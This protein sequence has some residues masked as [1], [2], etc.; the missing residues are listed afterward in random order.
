M[1]SS[2]GGGGGGRG[3]HVRHGS[4]HLADK[5]IPPSAPVVS[6]WRTPWPLPEPLVFRWRR[7]VGR[8][9]GARMLNCT[10]CCGAS[11]NSGTSI[12]RSR[13]SDY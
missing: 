6:L 11:T 12:V 2:S 5:T 7:S 3:K 13:D 4:L 8:D 10:H 9:G 1:Q